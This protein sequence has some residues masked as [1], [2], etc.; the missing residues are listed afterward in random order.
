[1]HGLCSEFQ[2]A[3]LPAPA[4]EAQMRL[5]FDR[6]QER[7]QES[8]N[9]EIYKALESLTDEQGQNPLLRAIFGCSPYL[10]QICLSDPNAVIDLMRDGPDRTANSILAMNAT[11]GEIIRIKALASR[12]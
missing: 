2:N 7:I 3:A 4:D 9:S 10:T 12:A 5:G 6:W 1:M 8:D 11:E